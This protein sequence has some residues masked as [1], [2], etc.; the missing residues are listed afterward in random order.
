MDL[1]KK[2]VE[3]NKYTF[4]STGM[5]TIDEIEKVVDLF[6]KSSVSFELMHCN[7]TYPMKDEEANLRVIPFL[8]DRFKCDVGYSGHEVGLITSA[9][10]VPFGITS[11]ERHI[12]LDRAMYGSDQA[13]SVE[14]NGF[15]KLVDYVRTAEV[16]LGDGVKNITEGEKKA[17]ASL[18]RYNDIEVE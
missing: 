6:R 4:I 10:A 18:R 17:M 2:V 1:L 15:S 14:V 3:L 9:A 16:A 12:T 13:A 8:Q 11:L 7:S 5:S